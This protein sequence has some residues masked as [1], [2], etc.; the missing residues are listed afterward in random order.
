MSLPDWE[1]N[2]WLTRHQTSR[3]EI[4]DLLRVVERDLADSA[5]GGL[6]SDWRSR[7]YR[8]ACGSNTIRSRVRVACANRSS[9]LVD[10]R[11]LPPSIRAI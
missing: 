9:A 2:G 5:A 6:S 10:G 3:N 11:T 8:E 4:R 7:R 1:R